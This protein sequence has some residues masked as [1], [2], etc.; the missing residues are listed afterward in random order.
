MKIQTQNSNLKAVDK[1]NGDLAVVIKN[2]KSIPSPTISKDHPGNWSRSI[3]WA[4]P[5]AFL[6]SAGDGLDDLKKVRAVGH[7]F[8]DRT[9]KYGERWT[10]LRTLLFFW[11]CR[12]LEGCGNNIY[13]TQTLIK[14]LATLFPS[15]DWES[16]TVNHVANK[17]VAV[18]FLARLHRI[19]GGGNN[20]HYSVHPHVWNRGGMHWFF[21]PRNDIKNGG[22]VRGIA[23]EG[24]LL[25]QGLPTWLNECKSIIQNCP[26]DFFTKGKDTVTESDL[27][28][29]E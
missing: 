1:Q 20:K 4:Q 23:N 6:Q 12:Q 10:P 9:G 22:T 14:Y 21:D 16:T 26:K 19:E 11:F 13:S 5:H 8:P 28:C 15:A 7:I 3:L 24:L 29:R 25:P 18:G 17:L 2:G 27:K